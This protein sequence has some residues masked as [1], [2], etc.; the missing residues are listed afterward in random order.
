MRLCSLPRRGQALSN[1]RQNYALPKQTNSRA[2]YV[3]YY[4]CIGRGVH[5]R[6]RPAAHRGG[7]PP[8]ATSRPA[9]GRRRRPRR[10]C[11]EGWRERWLRH[12]PRRGSLQSARVAGQQRRAGR[13]KGASIWQ[14]DN[15]LFFRP[16]LG[17][18]LRSLSLAGC[19]VS[20]QRDFFLVT[21]HSKHAIYRDSGPT[22]S[23][24]ASRQN[25]NHHKAA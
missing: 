1:G 12:P 16:R 17:R 15:L 14:E 5:H 4:V 9:G 23:V 19:F 10:R 3:C 24:P 13:S 25:P 6:E 8:P 11:R 18:A 7:G 22:E 2:P 21:G 20:S